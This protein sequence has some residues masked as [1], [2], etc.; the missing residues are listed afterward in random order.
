MTDVDGI[1]RTEGP[2]FGRTLMERTVLIANTEHAGRRARS[3]RV[4]GITI[5]EYFRDM[6]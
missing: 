6:G 2:R 4:H 5:A 3:Q 1:P